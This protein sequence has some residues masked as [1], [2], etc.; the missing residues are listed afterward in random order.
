MN[1]PK[2]KILS[3]LFLCF[4]LNDAQMISNVAYH[5]NVL[6]GLQKY[7]YDMVLLH[8]ETVT[9]SQLKMFQ[10]LGM[11]TYLL[12]DDIKRLYLSGLQK[13]GGWEMD[14]IDVETTPLDD[15]H[16]SR[17]NL[18]RAYLQLKLGATTLT[19]YDFIVFS[20]FDAYLSE[21]FEKE[22]DWF[23]A[24][25]EIKFVSSRTGKSPINAGHWIIEPSLKAAK[26]W[27]DDISTGFT[28]ESGWNKVGKV[29]PS[30]VSKNG[31]WH[32]G[33]AE[34]DQGL[35]YHIYGWEF[36]A[37]L[38]WSGHY[39]LGNDE[40][41]PGIQFL[42]DENIFTPTHVQGSTVKP[43]FKNACAV[44]GML[45]STMLKLNNLAKPLHTAVANT[46]LASIGLDPTLQAFMNSECT[47][48]LKRNAQTC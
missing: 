37:A 34:M 33:G 1:L 10:N 30:H 36:R 19:E 8:D 32:F 4:L 43:W 21:N 44:E 20:D 18:K 42:K 16:F 7:A 14:D 35:L 9:A 48:I 40:P 46:D 12:G 17:R 26:I 23:Q 5:K 31:S 6:A 13:V 39:K 45:N 11:R 28:Y 2:K 29:M 22:L 24:H 15:E 41:C 3:E 47:P 38:A 25:T 27:L